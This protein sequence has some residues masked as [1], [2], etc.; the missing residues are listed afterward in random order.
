MENLNMIITVFL[1]VNTLFVFRQKLWQKSI[2]TPV[3][4][5]ASDLAYI[6]YIY[7][8]NNTAIGTWALA[9]TGLVANSAFREYEPYCVR[10]YGKHP[11]T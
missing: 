3:V 5:L 1:V 2:S 8:Q 9:V 7:G 11:R 4:I 10:K 6:L